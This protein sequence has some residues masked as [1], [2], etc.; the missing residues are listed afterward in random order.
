MSGY[1]QWPLVMYHGMSTVGL[2][3]APQRDH[4]PGFAVFFLLWV[5]IE[6]FCVNNLVI[7]VVV[8]NFKQMKLQEAGSLYLL[9]AGQREWVDTVLRAA[10][11]SR[12]APTS[13]GARRAAL[14]E[15]ERDSFEVTVQT[16]IVANVALMLSLCEPRRGVGSAASQ[17]GAH[18]AGRRASY[19]FTV[20]LPRDG[21]QAR[22][23]QPL[24]TRGTL[25]LCLVLPRSS[26]CTWTR[27]PAA[28]TRRRL[29]ELRST[30]PRCA[31]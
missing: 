10:R 15:L 9:S 22:R 18:A 28:T 2:D 11:S 21:P 5:F 30:R 13:P 12:G 20:L 27:R 1:E 7:G 31:S 29:A 14:W 4:A 16:L 8:A 19:F 6:A 23:L 24:P 3:V 26:T 25:P 17:G